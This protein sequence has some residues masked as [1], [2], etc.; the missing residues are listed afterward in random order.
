[1]SGSGM[2]PSICKSERELRRE[3]RGFKTGIEAESK[4]KRQ[5][6]LLK[7]NSSSAA[8]PT[9]TRLRYLSRNKFNDR[10]VVQ[11]QTTTP[12]SP[13]QAF[14]C[15]EKLMPLT[16][17][18]KWD[19]ILSCD[20]IHRELLRAFF[21]LSFLSAARRRRWRRRTAADGYQLQRNSDQRHRVK[22]LNFPGS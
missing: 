9:V 17:F 19:V 5:T 11:C 13:F 16:M 4:F 18:L 10:Y 12:G 7:L 1:M 20:L 22:I 3:T 14:I 21:W 15:I 2:L 6:N 8:N